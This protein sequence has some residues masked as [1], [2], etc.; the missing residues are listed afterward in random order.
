MT[1]D[2]ADKNRMVVI[3]YSA[4]LLLPVVDVGCPANCRVK[5][6]PCVIVMVEPELL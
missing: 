6:P 5:P 1:A 2:D 4:R 3:P